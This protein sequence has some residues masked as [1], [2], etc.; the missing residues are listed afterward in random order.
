MTL[1][2][3]LFFKYFNKTY[4]LD[5]RANGNVHGS[6]LNLHTGAF[7]DNNQHIDDVLFATSEAE[8]RTINEDRFVQQT[9]IERQRYLRGD[10]PIFAFYDTI[11]G[12]NDQALAEN[13]KYAPE[14]RALIVTLRKRTFQ[15]WEEEFARRAAGEP[16]S[17][18]FTSAI[19]P[20]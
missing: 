20:R 18:E 11:K 10:G 13:R 12:I 5:R 3:P 15:I 7:E 16:P 6:M 8:I 1:P 9:K 4:K 14:E 17:F 19:P 2:M